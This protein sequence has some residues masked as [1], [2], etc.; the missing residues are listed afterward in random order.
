MLEKILQYDTSWLIAINNSGSEKFDAFWLFV[1]HTPHWI[2]FF[3]LL[4]LLN[5]Y[6]FKRKEAFRNM[7]FIL[8]TLAT[9]LLLV[10]ITK[11]LVMRLRPLNDPSIAPHLRFLIP[12]DGYSFF[13]GHSCNSFSVATIV[14]LLFRQKKRW[15]FWVFLWPLPYAFSRM[16]L[17]VHFPSDIFVGM[18]VGVG[19]ALF[20]YRWYCQKYKMISLEK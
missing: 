12:A 20:Y 2:P 16:Y 17:G 14:F 13:S 3:L 1:T 19:T 4:L 18:L 6:W 8:L 9:T 10:A 15:V 11:E 5:F 7:F